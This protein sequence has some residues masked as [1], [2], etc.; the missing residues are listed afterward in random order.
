MSALRDPLRVPVV[1]VNEKE[2]QQALLQPLA[3]TGF[4]GAADPV[5]LVLLVPNW[6][7]RLLS[8]HRTRFWGYHYGSVAAAMALVGVVLG[9]RRLR[10]SGRAGPGLVGYL[11]SCAA[12]V[13][14]LPPY[15][16][17]AG[18]PRSDLYLLHQPYAS[19]GEDVATQREAVA[20]VGRDP[21]V[22][23]AAQ[24]NLLPHLAT[25]PFVYPLAEAEGADV[26]ALQLNGGTSPGGRA[27]YRRRVFE[28]WDG[29]G[30]EVAFC[31]G[32]SVVLRRVGR[33]TAVPCPAWEAFLATRRPGEG[34]AP[35]PV[36]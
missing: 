35:E 36:P 4:L 27:G 6:A 22:R 26:I 23:V 10:E 34:S 20:F 16:T 25:R 28:L 21:A 31:R 18:N 17:A 12:L 14:L 29:G 24:Y 3:A 19:Q 30:F 5:S 13:G 7:E 11:L 15:R 32:R 33:G 1:L 2:K 9:G 8:S